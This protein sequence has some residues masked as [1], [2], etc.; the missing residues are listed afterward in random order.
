MADGAGVTVATGTATATA[1]TKAIDLGATVA[2]VGEADDGG[3]MIGT[4]ATP[5]PTAAEAEAA[6]AKKTRRPDG[7]EDNA[8]D[9][10]NSSYLQE[11]WADA[12]GADG[13]GTTVTDARTR[14]A[15]SSASPGSS[16]D[17]CGAWC[18]GVSSRACF[19]LCCFQFVSLHTH[20]PLPFLIIC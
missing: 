6:Q 8:G 7:G 17:R 9:N 20:T 10:G 1:G 19:S 13:P 11:A 18:C 3:A 16:R 14:S 4:A 12:R 15:S 2:A 5:A